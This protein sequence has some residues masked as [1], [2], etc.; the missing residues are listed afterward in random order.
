MEQADIHVEIGDRTW[1]VLGRGLAEVGRR[2]T[3]APA[4]DERAVS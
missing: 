1:A 4:V 2:G 3:D